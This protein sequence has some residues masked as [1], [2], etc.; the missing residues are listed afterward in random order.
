M[1]AEHVITTVPGSPPRPSGTPPTS[2]PHEAL[3][4]LVD[5]LRRHPGVDGGVLLVRDRDARGLTPAAAWFAS[6]VIGA[7]AQRILER[8][9]HAPGAGLAEAALAR[10]ATLLVP[11]LADWEGAEGLRQLI[12]RAGEGLAGELWAAYGQASGVACPVRGADGQLIGALEVLSFAPERPLQ[13][14]DLHGL[15]L[16]ADLAALSYERSVAARDERARA[17]AEGQLERAAM[18]VSDS[19]DSDRVLAVVLEHALS[20]VGAH[21]ASISRLM[22]SGQI[23]LAAAA[24]DGAAEIQPGELAAV[25]R[26]GRPRTTSAGSHTAHLPLGAG[27]RP[28]GVLSVSRRLRGFTSE[29]LELLGRLARSSVAAIVNADHFEQERRLARAL[30]RGFVPDSLPPVEDYEVAALFEPAAGHAAGGDV[31]G[32]WTRPCG[33]LAI[34]IGDVAGKGPAASGL[35]TMARFFIEARSWEGA[36]PA[37]VLAE[38]AAMLHDRLPEDTFVTAFLAFVQDGRLRCANAGHL[39]PL[40]ARR[41]GAT[42]PLEAR[43]LPLGTDPAPNYDEH[44]VQ[45]EPGDLLYAYSDGLTEA[46]RDGEMF[47]EERLLAAIDSR[48]G[49]PGGVV[50][51]VEALHEEVR[52]WAGGLLDDSTALCLRRR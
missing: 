18:E 32:L 52:A 8:P 15:E 12:D 44:V 4:L 5:H 6:P 48:R 47:G 34:L 42:E 40:L 16:M 51:L 35:S 33:D 39:P 7:A 24:D 29:E 13:R 9:D 50:E 21:G 10:D 30:T 14:D 26:T 11:R 1:Q 2:S 22:P 43:G 37:Q 3:D 46:R 17:Q 19:L 49:E 36:G 28:L 41:A 45:L 27:P 25:A 38:S 31:Y 20:L 23:S